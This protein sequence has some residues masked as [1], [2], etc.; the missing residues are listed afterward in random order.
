MG[1][2]ARFIVKISQLDKSAMLHMTNAK[3]LS[4]IQNS[5]YAGLNLYYT[6][7]SRWNHI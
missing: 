1:V 3:T 6:L 4:D 7:I 5:Y 2:T